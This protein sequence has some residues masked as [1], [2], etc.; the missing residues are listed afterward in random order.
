VIPIEGSKV[1]YVGP[2]VDGYAIGD[3]AVVLASGRT[4]SHFSFRTGEH[5][6]TIHYLAN[7]DFV[8][9]T[10]HTAS[11]WDE[12]L[13]T[14]TPAI[15]VRAAYDAGGPK[16]VVRELRSNGHLAAMEQIGDEAIQLV[17][18]RLRQDPSV[19]AVLAQ[20]DAEEGSGFVSYAAVQVLR[21]VLG[22]F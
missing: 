12:A 10:A 18:A 6:G 3:H 9:P 8:Q 17:A 5:E 15:A 19:L 1:S 21:G 20:L 4:H 14:D 11:A 22:G 16:R 13:E 2:E 7:S